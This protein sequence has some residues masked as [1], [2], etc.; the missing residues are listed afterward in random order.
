M[1]ASGAKGSKNDIPISA[2]WHSDAALFAYLFPGS[3]SCV[4]A[5]LRPRLLDVRC[6]LCNGDY[7]FERLEERGAPA[8]SHGWIG[9]LH[10]L[11]FSRR[12]SVTLAAF[13]RATPPSASLLDLRFEE[14]NALTAVAVEGISITEHEAPLIPQLK[15]SVFF[16]YGVK[17]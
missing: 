13:R 4:G 9:Y 17:A 1:A 12:S 11:L 2:E 14:R 5:E 10:C 15:K 3:P 8:V 6:A 7:A 16:Q